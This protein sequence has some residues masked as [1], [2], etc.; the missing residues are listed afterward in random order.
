MNNPFYQEEIS[1]DE[2]SHIYKVIKTNI[3]LV[4]VTTLL[5]QYSQPFDPF[6][7]ILRACAKRDNI[8]T[9]ELQKKWDD[10]RNLAC[11]VGSRFHSQAEEYIKMGEIP[12]GP[13]RD[14]L[15]DFKS[16]VKFTGQVYSE[17]LLYSIEHGLAG[18]ADLI[19]HRPETNS[20][21]A[22]DFKTNGIL[23]KDGYNGA[24]M[25]PP[26]SHLPDAN[27]SIYQ[28]QLSLYCYLLEL[29]GFNVLENDLEIYWVNPETRKIEIIPIPYL[30]AEVID[31]LF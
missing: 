18:M 30:R 31:L 26:V 24:K 3:P 12:D 27:L 22:K 17:V 21:S 23:K 13:D 11:Y 1:F 14:I 10:K 2:D 19:I 8:S 20:I 15:E 25:K 4:S 29:K 9:T 7:H 28:L 5:H 6:G 16:K